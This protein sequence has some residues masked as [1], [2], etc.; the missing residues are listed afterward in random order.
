MSH[1]NVSVTFRHT[2]PSEALKSYAAEKLQRCGR[3][4]YR[5]LD[6]HVVLAVDAKDR[7]W[8]EVILQ[9]RRLKIHGHDQTRDL[10]SALD[11]AIEKVEQQ[12]RRYKARLRRRRHRF[13]DH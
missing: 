10:Y 5:P 6:A 3:Y 7:H 12:I 2:R 4:F 8:A 13:E 1:V 9:T 11:S